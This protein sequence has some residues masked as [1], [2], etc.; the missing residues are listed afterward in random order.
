MAC[1]GHGQHEQEY[2]STTGK[3]KRGTGLDSIWRGASTSTSEREEARSTLL[4]VCTVF[5]S[6][7]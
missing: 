7:L 1:L 2:E 4:R 3:Q 5:V 6:M